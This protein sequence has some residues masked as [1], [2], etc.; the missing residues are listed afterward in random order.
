ME[1]KISQK[2][3]CAGVLMPHPPIIVHEVGKGR[4][5]DAA[6][7]V[8][9]CQRVAELIASL[10]P[11]T[12]VIISPHSPLFSD[13]LFI[14]DKPV[15]SG[16]FESFGVPEL[17]L[18]LPQDTPYRDS[19]CE[20]LEKAG[21]PAGSIDITQIKRYGIA[22]ELDHGV[23]VPLS[24]IEAA[25]GEVNLVALSSSAF[26]AESLAHCGVAL[27]DAAF[28]TGTRVCVVASGDM[29]HKVSSASPYG[30]VEEGA[31]FDRKIRHAI[32]LS[33]FAA[34]RS[35][36]PTLREKA[37]ECGYNSLLMMLS[38]LDRAADLRGITADP[39]V[40]GSVLSYEAPFGIGYCVAEFAF[41]GE[42][43]Q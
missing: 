42:D 41:S 23:L 30:K 38:A 14:H 21:I 29:S 2:G 18:S 26:E 10:E 43:A 8:T 9:A 35:I 32:E 17:R 25:C 34:I 36:D 16:S 13:F 6:L 33:D 4:E 22:D 31:K 3:I 24:F 5:H 39:A 15:L 11:D 19:L 27:A 7:T 28:A 12:I 20:H 40:T 37:A 1:S